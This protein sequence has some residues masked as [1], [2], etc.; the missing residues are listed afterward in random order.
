M[1]LNDIMNN[2]THEKRAMSLT[3]QFEAEKV[4][5]LEQEAAA[6][7]N[8]KASVLDEN[9]GMT[10]NDGLFQSYS[11]PYK[12]APDFP[13]Y[14]WAALP[15]LLIAF[16]GKATIILAIFGTV[17]NFFIIHIYTRPINRYLLASIVS[18]AVVLLYLLL[19]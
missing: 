7:A 17:V 2:M 8:D 3:E 9:V 4:A 1:I 15:I 10:N 16:G 12:R 18:V 14:L 13:L 6:L 5:R 11:N 19:L